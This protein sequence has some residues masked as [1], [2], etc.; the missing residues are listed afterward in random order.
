MS[1]YESV[2]G[3]LE[4]VVSL[5]SV[6]GLYNI[7]DRNCKIRIWKGEVVDYRYCTLDLTQSV[8]SGFHFTATSAATHAGSYT[9]KN[10]MI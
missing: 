5:C 1:D 10:M 7:D 8:D 6:M 4:I 2:V 9:V 3:G